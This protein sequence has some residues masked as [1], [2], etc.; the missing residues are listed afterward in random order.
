MDK[1]TTNENDKKVKSHEY[2]P[3]AAAPLSRWGIAPQPSA[4]ISSAGHPST[5]QEK[6]PLTGNI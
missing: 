2:P 5:A 3:M 1:K 4:P 6:P